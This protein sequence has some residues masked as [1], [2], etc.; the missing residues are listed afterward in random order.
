MS[1]FSRKQ[2][3]NRK[4]NKLKFMPQHLTDIEVDFLVNNVS[5]TFLDNGEQSTKFTKSEK[6]SSDFIMELFNYVSKSTQRTKEIQAIVQKC[7]PEQ[8]EWQG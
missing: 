1:N 8:L 5:T 2:K 3:Q 7:L 4:P 6:I